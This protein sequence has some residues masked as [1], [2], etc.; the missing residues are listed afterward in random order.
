[1]GCYLQ[2]V[3]SLAPHMFVNWLFLG[4]KPFH[5]AGESKINKTVTAPRTLKGYTHIE[6]TETSHRVKFRVM[7]IVAGALPLRG[8]ASCAFQI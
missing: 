5:L 4:R 7:E 2:K 8:I 3:E 1:M 6:T